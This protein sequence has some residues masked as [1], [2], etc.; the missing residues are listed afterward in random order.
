MLSGFAN[1]GH[2]TS[3]RDVTT[4]CTAQKR[5]RYAMH[6]TQQVKKSIIL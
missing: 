5:E 4:P 3:G 1:F 2:N 6:Q